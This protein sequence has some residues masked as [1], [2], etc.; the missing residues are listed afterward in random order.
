MVRLED[1]DPR[2]RF[3]GP[4]GRGLPLPPPEEPSYPEATPEPASPTM[5]QGSNWRQVGHGR[6]TTTTPN[7][8]LWT[9]RPHGEVG[10]DQP[11]PQHYPQA[12][13]PLAIDN[14]GAALVYPL[15]RDHRMALQPFGTELSPI[16]AHDVPQIVGPRPDV[17]YWLHREGTVRVADRGTQTPLMPALLPSE[18]QLNWFS[19]RLRERN[20]VRKDPGI[21]L[22]IDD[23]ER[24]RRAVQFLIDRDERARGDTFPKARGWFIYPDF[25]FR[26][27]PT[28]EESRRGA[29]PW[30]PGDGDAGPDQG[31][32]QGA[33][34]AGSGL[35]EEERNTTAPRAGTGSGARVHEEAQPMGQADGGQVGSSAPPQRESDSDGR[36]EEQF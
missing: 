15:P 35:T 7:P 8:R 13:T 6:Y 28:C 3:Q 23:L 19:N 17:R 33:G 5:P 25:V 16:S 30:M 2:R 18:R 24:F 36:W 14:E 31:R 34:S 20:V 9:W 11:R 27:P 4:P 26:T 22:L 10:P 1:S 12:Q 29:G 32:A 21:N